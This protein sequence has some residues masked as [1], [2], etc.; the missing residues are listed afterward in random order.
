MDRTVFK[1]NG[2]IYWKMLIKSLRYDKDQEKIWAVGAWYY[3]R[4]DL[5]EVKLS[6]R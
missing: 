1:H 4:S 2:N 6:D 5:E 3:S